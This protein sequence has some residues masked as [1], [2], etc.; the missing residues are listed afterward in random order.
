MANESSQKRSW[1]RKSF[2]AV[3]ALLVVLIVLAWQADL[4]SRKLTAGEVDDNRSTADPNRVVK[5]RWDSVPRRRLL[6]GAVAP[7]ARI[8]LSARISGQIR[9]MLVEEGSRVARGDPVAVLDQSVPKAARDEAAAAL[10]M[11]EAEPLGANRLLEHIRQ[12]VEARAMPQTELVDAERS[13][14]AASRAVERARAA[15]QAAEARLGFARIESP[16]DGVVL[17]TLKDSGDQVLPGRPVLVMYDPQQLEAVVSV[18]ESLASHFEQGAEATCW[19]EALGLETEATVR[20]LVPGADP[21]SRTVLAK[22]EADLPKRA[23]PGMYAQV[24]VDA[25]PDN[26]VLVPRS[27]VERVRQ[28]DFVRVVG[29]DNRVSRRIVRLGRSLGEDVIVLAG[30]RASERVIRQASPDEEAV[31]PSASSPAPVQ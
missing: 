9:E 27:A 11:A 3:A 21:A 2:R 8:E 23:V 19:I 26:A 12:A 25:E 28:L 16:A 24:A 30:L 20:V 4:F 14:D 13:R 22:L 15:L 10:A 29:E 7:R 31:T 5:A 18:P 1:L 6:V 17:E